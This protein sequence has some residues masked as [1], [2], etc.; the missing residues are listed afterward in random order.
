MDQ[1]YCFHLPELIDRT[2]DIKYVLATKERFDN[3]TKEYFDNE[4]EKE[5][6]KKFFVDSICGASHSRSCLNVSSFVTWDHLQLLL[7][8][9]SQALELVRKSNFDLKTICARS[10]LYRISKSSE[11]DE[12]NTSDRYDRIYTTVSHPSIVRNLS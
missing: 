3:E 6:L 10:F 4:T 11:L 12:N 7:R 2:I 9:L 8:N 1:K 5:A